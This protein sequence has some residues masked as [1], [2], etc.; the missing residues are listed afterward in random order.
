MNALI[1][2]IAAGSNL[3]VIDKNGNIKTITDYTQL[4]PGEVILTKG[5]DPMVSDVVI[6]AAIVGDEGEITPLDTDDEIAQILGQLEAG[7]DPTQLGDEFA[8]AAGGDGTTGSSTTPLP[9]IARTGAETIASTSFDTSGLEAQGL[10]AFQANTLLTSQQQF[11]NNPPSV[12]LSGVL[13]NIDENTDTTNRIKIADI[14]IIDDEQGANVLSL[15][16]TDADKFEI[17]GSELYLRA[18]QQLDHETLASMDVDVVVTDTSLAGV[19]PTSTSTTLDVNDIN[20]APTVAAPLTSETDEGKSEYKIDLL[21]GAS[22]VDDGDVLSVANVSSLP[23]GF[24]LDGNQIKVDPSNSVFNSMAVGETR[25]V[26]VSYDVVD[27]GGLSVPNTV[28]IT[29]TGTNDAAVVSEVTAERTEDA[30]EF[31]VNLLENSSD[32]DTSDVL[33]VSDVTPVGEPKGVTVDGGELIVDPNAYNY[34]AAGEKAVIKYTYNVLEKDDEGNLID[35][36]PTTATITITGKN[37]AAVVSEVTAE[38]TEDADE[39]RVNLLENSSD[40]D[41]SDV[42]SVSDVTPVGEPKGVTVDGG[43]LIVDPNAYNYLA[44]GEKAVIKY[45]YNVLEKDDEGNLIDTHPTTATITITGKND[46][47]VVSEVT[48]ERTEDTDEFR[49]NLLENSSDADTSD[50]L[51]VSD[52]T[53]VGEPKG[54]TVDG[55]ELIVDPNA[56]NT[57]AGEKSGY[58]IHL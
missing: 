51:S 44:A 29:V 38:R 42:L 34:L 3:V 10:T 47:A 49:V 11:I 54:V 14:S 24:V 21:Q 5:D 43:E 19:A 28:T 23:T 50:V 58:Q 35:T 9:T 18:G 48:A 16:G 45:T 33:S 41:T 39:F 37:D 1:G 57:F 13:L 4:L 15:T 31:R 8:T 46:A 40:A 25:V 7:Q 17:I 22:D 26:S 36:H 53:P 56:Y 6:E 55:G 32:A 2:G 12:A 27:S 52:V 20:E 30:D